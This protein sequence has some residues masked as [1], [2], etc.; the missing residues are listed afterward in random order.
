MAPRFDRI[1]QCLWW[2]DRRVE[3]SANAFNLLRYLVERP[4]QLVT[5]SELLDAVWPDAYVVDAVLSVTISQLR[6]AFGD[7]ARQPRFIETVYGRGYRWVGYLAPDEP[8]AA[9]AVRDAGAAPIVGRDAALAELGAALARAAAGNRQLV[10]IT[11]DPGIGKTA[12]TDRFLASAAA[13]AAVS[14]RGQCVDAYGMAEP[15]MPL[16]EAMQQLVRSIDGAIDVLRAQ[17]PTWLLQLPGL[18]SPGEHDE[19]QR[20]LI[21][22]PD[23]ASYA[24][25]G[26]TPTAPPEDIHI[27]TVT[28]VW[29]LIVAGETPL[30]AE[31]ET[32][33]DS[34]T[35]RR[36]LCHWLEEGSLTQ[37]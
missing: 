36:L 9:T 18:L 26:V 25:T 34:Y 17:A 29:Q 14:A 27:D 1:N 24:T 21:L 23:R 7:A 3:L 28:G 4:N 20:A 33:S 35:V 11:G 19:L 16:L 31:L 37:K 6:E 15:Y 10:L 32:H 13:P 12:L 2:D 8:P 5:K 22:V 30:E